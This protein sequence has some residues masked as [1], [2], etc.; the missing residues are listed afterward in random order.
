MVQTHSHA[1]VPPSHAAPTM[2]TADIILYAITHTTP[3]LRQGQQPPP[4]PQP[5]QL[6][7][8]RQKNTE[9]ILGWKKMLLLPL[10]REIM[11]TITLGM[12]IIEAATLTKP[13][14]HIIAV[15]MKT[16]GQSSI[17]TSPNTSVCTKP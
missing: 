12:L 4:Q 15:G 13:K 1:R 17:V 8:R 2:T 7:Q 11:V 10:L 14:N 5:P 16:F 9:M 6:Q 3:P